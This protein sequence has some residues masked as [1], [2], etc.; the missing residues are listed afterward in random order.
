MDNCCQDKAC[1]LDSLRESQSRIL[2]LVLGINSGMFALEVT[3]GF[4]AGSTALLAD[5]LDMLGDSLVYGFSLFVVAR[6]ARWRA[7]AAL[8]KGIIMAGFGLMVLSQ[9][10]YHFISS[11]VPDFW[12]MGIVGVLALAANTT[13]LLLLTRHRN[14]DLNMRSTWICSRNDI[15]ANVG[16]LVA[17]ALVL[18][19]GSMWPDLV[20]GLMI[21]AIFMRSAVYVVRMAVRELGGPPAEALKWQVQ[22]VVL[23]LRPCTADT[24]P[25]GSCL[26]QA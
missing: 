6:S 20:L 16:I 14:D 7:G 4:W 25:A 1:E 17:A 19:T 22:P 2:W 24:C 8:L 23:V 12:L 15:I 5:S 11:E 3:L 26:C 18:A 9:A 21:A 10:G 13:C